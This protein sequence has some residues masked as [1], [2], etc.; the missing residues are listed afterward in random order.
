MGLG[1]YPSHPPGW[2]ARGGAG[3]LLRAGP[4][5]ASLI[6]RPLQGPTIAASGFRWTSAQPSLWPG[7]WGPPPLYCA[8]GG[9]AERPERAGGLPKATQPAPGRAARVATAG[10]RSGPVGTLN[11]RPGR[12]R[13]RALRAG[14]I[15]D[16]EP[17]GPRAASSRRHWRA[18]RSGRG[19]DTHRSQPR[20]PVGLRLCRPGQGCAS[21]VRR[22][23]AETRRGCSG[24][25]H[26][27]K[28]RPP[29]TPLGSASPAHPTTLP[30]PRAP[31]ARRRRSRPQHKPR[32]PGACR[33]AAAGRPSRGR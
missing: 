27:H 6:W 16:P 28:P 31:P 1:Q 5:T 29:N 8:Q 4:L 25:A 23:V 30:P 2:K 17:S 21:A 15:A 26:R 3:P 13:D 33:S 24:P 10:Q 20:R 11:G 14:Q 7:A 32:P 12:Q 22:L 19:T 18:S 9:A